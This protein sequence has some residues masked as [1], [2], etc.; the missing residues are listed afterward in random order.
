MNFYKDFFLTTFEIAFA[1]FMIIFGYT[2]WDNFDKSEY[3]T[4]KYY[5][6][7][8]YYDIYLEDINNNISLLTEE[9]NTEYAKLYLHNI[10]DKNNN[11]LLTFKINKENTNLINNTI[12]KIE[13]KYYEINK[14]N[15]KEDEIYYYFI[16]ENISFNSYETKEYDIKVL[17]KEEQYNI[18]NYIDYEFVTYL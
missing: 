8:E 2:I 1:I 17:L 13:D 10:S 14:L 18:N 6:N 5:D 15:Y 4:A 11:T 12:I 16:L 7:I 3:N 9:N